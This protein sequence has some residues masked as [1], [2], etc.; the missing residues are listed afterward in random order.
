M[1]KITTYMSSFMKK[2][3]LPSVMWSNV[4][5]S[6]LHNFTLLTY[7]LIMKH[8]PH[9]RRPFTGGNQFRQVVDETRALSFS[10]KWKGENSIP[11]VQR[12][13]CR[14]KGNDFVMWY[15]GG[16]SVVMRMWCDA[17]LCLVA[18]VFGKAIPVWPRKKG[19]I[20]NSSEDC[21]VWVLICT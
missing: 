12:V 7:F 21:V 15:D 5:E 14:K 17:S 6:Y 1:K 20:F 11:S 19:L 16:D 4:P 18:W 9:C 13:C 3:L 8:E 10:G 2:T